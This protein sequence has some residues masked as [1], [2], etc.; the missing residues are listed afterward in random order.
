MTLLT[1]EY[2]ATKTYTAQRD[3]IMLA[4]LEG[5]QPGVVAAGDFKVSQRALGANM[6][7][8]VAAGDAWVAGTDTAR[9]GMYHAAND[10]VVNVATT[11]AGAAWAV[12]DATNPRL[13]QIILR[14]FDTTDG[15]AANG[16]NT[17]DNVQLLV[18]QGT[19]TAGATLDTRTGAAALPSSCIRIADVLIPAATSTASTANI[20]DRRPWARGAYNKIVRITNASAGADYTMASGTAAEI[21][22]TNLK[23]RIELSGTANVRVS[24]RGAYAHNTA[25][26]TL[27]LQPAI[28]GLA[29][30]GGPMIDE[31]PCRPRDAG[32]TTYTGFM[33]AWD[34]GLPN[35]GSH[36]LSW[37]WR[38]LIGTAALAANTNQM[39]EMT[40]E[41]IVRQNAN[42]N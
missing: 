3:R 18:L 13:D 20:R 41:E 9:Q 2:F 16:N 36:L 21:D 6:S 34:F 23:P 31:F 24:L 30:E 22:A 40:V 37:T 7:V 4:A 38:S 35:A 33:F 27:I 1:P 8:D 12:G 5:I 29:V 25:G 11:T 28:D 17:A 19:A 15:A 26:G 14:V 10:A 42:N 39:L 32:L